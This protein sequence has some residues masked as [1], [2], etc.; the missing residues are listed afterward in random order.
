MG[1]AGITSELRE[2]WRALASKWGASS[3]AVDAAFDDLVARYGEPHRRYHTLE[4][5]TE[6]LALVDGGDVELAVWF[7]DVIYDTATNDSEARSADYAVESLHRLGAPDDVVTEVRRLVLLTAGHVVDDGDDDGRTLVAADLA[8]LSADP[9]RYDRYARDVRAE[10]AHV[11]DASWR[12]GRASVLR[13]LL[14]VASD[15]RARANLNRELAR[16]ALPQT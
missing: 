9:E 1:Q 13:A 12:D 16:L 5:L 6:T 7:H 15:D 10:Y 11:D 8:I 3:I 4:H 14:D 2:R